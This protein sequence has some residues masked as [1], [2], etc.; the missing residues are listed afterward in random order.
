MKDEKLVSAFKEWI[1]AQKIPDAEITDAGDSVKISTSYAAGE[2]N[3][4]DLDVFIIEM[5]LTNLADGENKFYLH[6]ELKDLDYAQE[7]FSQMVET[8][9]DLKNQQSVK[10]LLSCTGG[11]TT[12]FFAQKLNDA[13][14]LLSLDYEFAAV[15]F[16]RLYNV[17][18]DYS[19]ILL[20]PQIAY[21][22]QHVQDILHDKLVLKIPPKVFASYDTAEMLKFIHAEL[23][24]FTKTVEERA[25]AKVR[26]GLI[27]SD[28]K[29]LS[30]AVMPFGRYTRIAY[31]IYEK[32]VPILN[33]MVIKGK[34]SILRDL[35]DILDT[36]SHRAAKYD[37]VGIAISGI[38][39][40]GHLQFNFYGD[41]SLNLQEILEEK[42]HVPVVI[43]NNVNAAVLGY[44]AQQDKYQNI[45]FF[46]RPRNFLASGLGLVING[47][48][49]PGAHNI[50]GEVKFLTREF[51]DEEDME[52]WR[53]YQIIDW[54]KVPDIIARE[55]RAGISVVDPELVCIRSEM[56][57]YISQIREK[58]TEYIPPEYLPDFVYVPDAAMAEYIL[59]GQMIL[60]LEAL[61][62][63]K[64]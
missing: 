1:L 55:I 49:I 2:V 17:G 43:T 13:V 15:P 51:L 14:K 28:A 58:L 53:R 26:A 41:M 7:L 42:Y 46:S 32:G 36:V 60:S 10:I 4:H 56:T 5:V 39:N 16:H 29:I 38:A 25:I 34:L 33:E 35:Q 22:F 18:F 9:T 20:A 59:L 62:A 6:F 40:A 24:K 50:A 47:K 52:S 61:E 23:E 11:M 57:P 48:M 31:R 54:S 37:T 3:F 64:K 45:M 63:R 12:S 30:I 21:E 27:K 44:Y 19:A 8:L